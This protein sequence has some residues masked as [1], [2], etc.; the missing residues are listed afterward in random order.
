M[1]P[2]FIFLNV[3]VYYTHARACKHCWRYSECS[4]AKHSFQFDKYR[5]NVEAEICNTQTLELASSK[6]PQVATAH[7]QLCVPHDA[8]YTYERTGY[9]V[10]SWD[11]QCLPRRSFHPKHSCSLPKS[12]DARVKSDPH[13]TCALSYMY[14]D[15]EIFVMKTFSVITFNDKTCPSLTK[16]YS[17]TVLL[18]TCICTV[19]VHSEPG[20]GVLINAGQ[21]SIQ[22]RLA[23][24]IDYSG[25]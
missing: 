16:A 19:Y 5:T 23:M 7:R 25:C 8:E 2:C 15:W 22:E 4:H 9:N 14:V 6:Q 20:I 13:K 10:S 18:D 12:L 11:R 21:E 24:Y 17:T 3:N 1:N